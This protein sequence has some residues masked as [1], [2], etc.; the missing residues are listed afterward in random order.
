MSE[1]FGGRPT[2][3]TVAQP[4]QVRTRHEANTQ[5]VTEAVKENEASRKKTATMLWLVVPALLTLAAAAYRTRERASPSLA[6]APVS[7]SVLE[8][9][10]NTGDLSLAYLSSGMTDGITRRLS[11]I[12]GVTVTKGKSNVVFST[13]LSRTNDSLEL[14]ANLDGHPLVTQRFTAGNVAEIES[15]I[16]IV[17]AGTVLR[18]P[19]PEVPRPPNPR[20][21][22]E[23]YDLTLKGWYT[24]LANAETRE[25]QLPRRELRAQEL[26][27]RATDIDP[28]NSRA[29]A[30]LASTW[31][32]LAITGEVAFS[33][34]YDR[35][36]A[37]AL[38]AIAIDSLEGSAWANYGILQGF[39]NHD[40]ASGLK[41]IDRALRAEPSNAE[42][43]LIRSGMLRAA[44]R[45]D[46]AREA[47]AMARV[48]D[49]TSTTYVNQQATVEFCDNKPERALRIFE[50][51]RRLNPDN[52]VALLGSIRALAQLRRFA[53]AGALWRRLAE[54]QGNRALMKD[55][56]TV[57]DS[58]SYWNLRHRQSEKRFAA[59]TANGPLSQVTSI[60]RYFSIGKPDS[61]YALM[62]VL[63]VADRPPLYR[64]SC[65]PDGDEYRYTPRFREKAEQFGWFAAH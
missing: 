18:R 20:I 55:L 40:V 21:D 5:V 35:G 24:L 19:L 28:K 30:G 47:I 46:E 11:R 64:L 57:N 50:D 58:A 27:K 36:T 3:E 33:D 4:D 8:M 48:L 65:N 1:S 51:E 41:L 26:F 49:P 32:G 61:A 53:E 34:G 63:P 12:A 37:S 17:M 25:S 44:H 31:A 7:V 54:S 59:L 13:S 52:Q 60:R 56:A 16:A 62:D 42:I 45:Y 10:N 14:N 2:P 29:I 43:Y 38:K 15:Q 9:K 39:R 23:S 6:V 22:S